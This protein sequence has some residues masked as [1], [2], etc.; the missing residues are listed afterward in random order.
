MNY[1]FAILLMGFIHTNPA[2]AEE[3]FLSG[4][5]IFDLLNDKTIQGTWY[6]REYTQTFYADG[7][8]SYIEGKHRP[9]FGKWRVNYD[10]NSF[11]SRWSGPSWAA[12]KITITAGTYHWK[13]QAGDDQPFSI[14]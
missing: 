2:S 14:K 12:Y 10:E 9:S 5:Q 11:E 13:Q 1:L 8:T 4:A 6:G 7:N 3:K